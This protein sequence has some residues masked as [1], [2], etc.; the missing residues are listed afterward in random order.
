MSTMSRV[1]QTQ[2]YMSAPFLVLVSDTNA[3]RPSRPSRNG[4]LA[5]RNGGREGQNGQAD[6]SRQEDIIPS[7]ESDNTHAHAPSPTRGSRGYVRGHFFFSRMY[8]FRG[9]LLSCVRPPSTLLRECCRGQR[10]QPLFV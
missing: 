3:R 4:R 6:A 5:V 8:V 7:R 1:R 2:W 10:L 9:R